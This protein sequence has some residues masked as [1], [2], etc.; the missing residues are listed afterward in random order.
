MSNKITKQFLQEHFRKH[1]SH[2]YK[3]DG[4]P[5]HLVKHHNLIVNGG[6]HSFMFRTYDELMDF[7][8][9]HHLCLKPVIAIG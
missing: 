2:A 9:K 8:K 5:R 7:Y 1:D 3:P 6:H 4:I